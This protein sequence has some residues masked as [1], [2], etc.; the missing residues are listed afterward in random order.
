[1]FWPNSDLSSEDLN[2][3]NASLPDGVD[4]KYS[5]QYVEIPF[6]LKMR[7]QEFGYI[8]Y[9][10]EVPRF[11]LGINTQARGD[12]SG[13]GVDT[14]KEDIQQDVRAFNMSWGIGGGIEYTISDNT[15]LVGGLFYQQ[16]FLDVTKDK[17]A[18]KSDG[19]AENSR[20]LLRNITV[21]IGVLF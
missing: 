17:N 3:S 11:V 13:T 12:I 16:G 9:F 14:E 15:S 6:A 4:L 5:L 19:S 20:G 21:R 8:R 1:N 18:V 10:F 7:T 2:N